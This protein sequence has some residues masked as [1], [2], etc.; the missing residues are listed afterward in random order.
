MSKVLMLD[1]GET[2]VHGTTVLPCVPEALAAFMQFEDPE[3]QPL[4]LCL[5]SDYEMPSPPVTAAK[6]K[7]MFPPLGF[8]RPVV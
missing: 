7:T 8:V 4:E 6:V 5:V 3:G 2:L 1:L